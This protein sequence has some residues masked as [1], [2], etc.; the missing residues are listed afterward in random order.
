[1]CIVDTWAY[2]VKDNLVIKFKSNNLINERL[3]YIVSI[4]L[5]QLNNAWMLWVRATIITLN[6]VCIQC[7]IM[8]TLYI[9]DVH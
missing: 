6:R 7:N 8:I 5:Q 4:K 1:M 3:H 9:Y 2:T